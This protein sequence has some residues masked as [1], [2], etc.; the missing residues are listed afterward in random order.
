MRE[1]WAVLLSPFKMTF[2]LLRWGSAWAGESGYLPLISLS[3]SLFIGIKMVNSLLPFYCF[4]LN[5][6]K[7]T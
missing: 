5:K 7:H 3:M 2:E 6:R 1:T 4:G